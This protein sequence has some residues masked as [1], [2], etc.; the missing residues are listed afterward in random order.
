[1]H[2][3]HVCDFS[4]AKGV[5]E[6]PGSSDCTIAVVS[7]RLRATR[8]EAP[9]PF[10]VLTELREIVFQ[11]ERP[12]LKRARVSVRSM[13]AFSASSRVCWSRPVHL[14]ELSQS[15]LVDLG[16]LGARHQALFWW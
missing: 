14:I 13:L 12:T 4:L 16:P 5:L 8:C 7:G 9:S 3:L 2:A 6:P 10:L 11:L 15:F 1:M